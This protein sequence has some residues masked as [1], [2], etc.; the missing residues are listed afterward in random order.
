MQTVTN[1]YALKFSNGYSRANL[2]N[3]STRTK[4]AVLAS[5]S[6]R[7]NGCFQKYAR[8]ARLADICQAVLRRLTR[9]AD[10]HQG[11]LRGLA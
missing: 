5:A 6:T 11:V 3:S 8:L 10:I 1:K 7:Q 9:I 2:A 4:L